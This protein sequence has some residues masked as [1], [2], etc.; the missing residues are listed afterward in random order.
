MM[1]AVDN[2][3]TVKSVIMRNVEPCRGCKDGL[4]AFTQCFPFRSFPSG[5]PTFVCSPCVEH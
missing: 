5:C 4:L 1:F 2:S 3:V